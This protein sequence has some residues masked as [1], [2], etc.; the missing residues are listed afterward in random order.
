M[1]QPTDS[2]VVIHDDDDVGPDELNL[3]S[4]TPDIR[5][6]KYAFS[7]DLG[8]KSSRKVYTV[9]DDGE[10]TKE[11]ASTYSSDPIVQFS[12]EPR[13]KRRGLVSKMVHQYE[14][15]GTHPEVEIPK[16][17]LI[18]E[19]HKLTYKRRMKGKSKVCRFHFN[20][21]LPLNLLKGSATSLKPASVTRTQIAQPEQQPDKIPVHSFFVDAK[22]WESAP[23]Q[24]LWMYTRNGRLIIE[25]N[26]S[27][28]IDELVNDAY[29]MLVSCR[30]L[31]N[32]IHSDIFK[33]SQTS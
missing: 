32:G 14:N 30:A 33:A 23:H 24:Q 5:P 27:K 2:P 3:R 29:T 16:L 15:N 25:E 6:S 13:E 21:I 1:F 11:I 20:S 12:P 7:S 22:L 4:D 17:D 9:I 26:S 31:I 28:L 10:T 19:T 18:E 8:L